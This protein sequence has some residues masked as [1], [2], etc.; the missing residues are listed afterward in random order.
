M[1]KLEVKN[2]CRCF[3]RSGDAQVQHFNSLAEVQEEAQIQLE[4]MQKNYC[5]KHRFVPSHMGG[6]YTIS[7][8]P[9]EMK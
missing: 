6:H 5:K 4:R 3:M 2:P 7:M 9:H 1:Y 8:L